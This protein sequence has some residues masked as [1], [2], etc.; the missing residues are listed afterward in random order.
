MYFRM[1]STFNQQID[2]E[3]SSTPIRLK[4]GQLTYAESYFAIKYKEKIE[5]KFSVKNIKQ[6]VEN[7]I[8]VI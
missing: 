8:D 1:S 7:E 2:V 6:I 3:E 5:P 4:V